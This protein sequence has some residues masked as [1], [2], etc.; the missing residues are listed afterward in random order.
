[1]SNDQALIR[2]LFEKYTN[3]S[4]SSDEVKQLFRLISDKQYDEEMKNLLL[5]KLQETELQDDYDKERWNAVFNQVKAETEL[6]EY[7]DHPKRNFGFR[8]LAVAAS[9]VAV[10]GT[11][12][13]L[14][15]RSVK[16]AQQIVQNQTQDILPGS[17][18]AILKTHGRQISITDA[19]NGLVAQMGSTSITKTANGKLVY[20]N[21]GTNAAMVYDTLIVPRGGQHLLQLADGTKILLDADSKLRY[22]ERF[23]SNERRIELI[24]GH[25][26]FYVH[27][28]AAIPFYVNVKGQTMKDIGTD[29]DISAY[30][31]EG[32][33]KTTLVEGSISVSS[34]NHKVTLKPGE[35]SSFTDNH[36]KVQA[37]DVDNV[38]AWSNG[39]FAFKQADIKTV[40]RQFSRWYDVVVE[41]EGQIP[42][43]RITGKAYRNVNASEALT[44]LT[45]LGIHY[46]I[47]NKK[48]IIIPN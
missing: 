47:E 14:Y 12:A 24:S 40:M 18:K 30:N 21:T 5:G 36:I 25:G 37:V 6:R 41:Y 29:F 11:G 1:M 10:V 15:F 19:K 42:T 17:D 33:V 3:G 48:I 27:H 44:I 13:Y 32:P 39:F 38:I 2:A 28:N 4:A 20:N 43:T 34:G 7:N 46:R 22:P 31:D 16:P 35:Q 9:I 26:R 45:D 8:K 23:A